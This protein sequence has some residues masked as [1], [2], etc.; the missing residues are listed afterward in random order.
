M[1]ARVCEPMAASIEPGEMP[2]RASATCASNTSR[3][4]RGKSAGDWRATVNGWAC[5]LAATATATGAGA[6]A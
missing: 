1:A 3:T 5:G 6:G 2:R 4:G